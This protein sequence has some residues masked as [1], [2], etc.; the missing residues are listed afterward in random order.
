MWEKLPVYSANAQKLGVSINGMYQATTLYYQQGLKTNEAMS[1][2]VETM[3]MAKIAGME[4]AEATEAMTAAL[5]GFN[6]E[7]N[8]TSAVK[9]NDVYSQL[10]AVTAADTEQIATAMS[11]TASIA[12]SANMEFETTAALLAQIIETTQEAPETAGTAMKTI[13]A[14]F[15]EVKSLKD[16]GQTTG[17]DSEG[18]TIDVNKIQ[19]ALRTVGISMEG[20]FNGTEGLD[21]VLLKLAE[22]WEG[23]DFK[24]QHYIAT[25][26]AGS[27]QQSRFIA[28][29]SDYGRTTELV[30]EAQ[31]STGASQK[32][33]EKTQDSLAAKLQR[34]SNA[35]D[36]F[37]MGLSNNE[38]IKGAV[39]FLTFVIEGVNKL[40]EALSGGNGLTK[41]LVSL[42]TVIG[43]LKLGRNALGGIMGQAAGGLGI[44][45][46]GPMK[47]TI[48]ETPGDNGSIVRT[49]VKEPVQQGEQVGAQA[50]Q[51]FVAG[52]KRAVSA[53]S[54][55]MRLESMFTT[56]PAAQA[57]KN[58]APNGGVGGKLGEIRNNKIQRKHE[59]RAANALK[60][61]TISDKDQ[62][63]V[64]YLSAIADRNSGGIKNKQ[65]GIDTLDVGAVSD[66]YDQVLNETG[67]VEQAVEAANAK[68]KELGG[69][70]MDSGESSAMLAE[71]T[72]GLT[73]NMGALGGAAMGVGGALGLLASLFQ[74]LGME[75]EKNCRTTSI[76]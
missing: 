31:S 60:A 59:N 16:S 65:G 40:T 72:N 11:K 19:T 1:L 30:G 20:F 38:I 69:T 51:G 18:E 2:G 23:L 25:M 42:M 70:F 4:S 22:K 17:Q 10:A 61:Q 48:T 64:N 9:V 7:L 71:Q 46:K 37:L 63:K 33:F 3:K 29:M 50:G 36:Q 76:Q 43:A 34:L 24:T 41:S 28:M 35:W 55:G 32:Q 56:G 39:D 13:I 6:M 14:R 53:D 21:S 75:E 15:S 66:V 67:S 57:D 54:K 44:G 5:R 26:A 73:L 27:R 12:A 8:E 58:L 68:V 49:I 47:E 62:G 45:S 74:S 52:F